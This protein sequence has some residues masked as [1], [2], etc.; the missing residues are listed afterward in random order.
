MLNSAPTL[1]LILDLL[2][3]DFAAG[4][5]QSLLK[6]FGFILRDAFFNRAWC[7]VSKTL[8]SLDQDQLLL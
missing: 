6:G 3:L 4:I 2:K 1:Y 8:A 7:T 5:F